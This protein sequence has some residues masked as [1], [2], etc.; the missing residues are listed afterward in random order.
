MKVAIKDAN[1]IFDLYELDL[2]EICLS[3]DFDF[4]TSDFVNSE[5]KTETLKLIINDYKSRNLIS[6]ESLNTKQL[7]EALKINKEQP[8]LSIPDCSV[9]ILAQKH[10]A[11]I[12]SGD[13]ALRNKAKQSGI[14][15]HGILW[16]LDTLIECNRITKETASIKLEELMKT[17]KRLPASDCNKRLE[18][19]SN[20]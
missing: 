20:K 6:I 14:E 4:I 3:L 1:I 11:I 12:L 5:I 8:G 19:W 17:N 15:Y 10:N 2:L 16:I 9:I 18:K 13:K 7:T